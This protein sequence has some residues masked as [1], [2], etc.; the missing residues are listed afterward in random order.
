MVGKDSHRLS[1]FCNW[2]GT[3]CTVQDITLYHVRVRKP[4]VASRCWYYRLIVAPLKKRAAASHPSL[5]WAALV[6]GDI[7]MIC[8]RGGCI[9]IKLGF[10]A[11]SVNIVSY[12]SYV[13]IAYIHRST[14]VFGR[15][16]SIATEFLA[17]IYFINLASLFS[18]WTC[19]DQGL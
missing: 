4:A 8:L 3:L 19:C 1:A 6:L 13:C 12:L 14:E 11:C 7:S 17:D 16:N 9:K 5:S 15:K 10:K 18:H 2:R